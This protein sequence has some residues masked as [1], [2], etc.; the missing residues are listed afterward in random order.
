MNEIITNDYLNDLQ[1]IKEAIRT[2]QNKAMV[3]VNSA[4]IMTYYEIGSRACRTGW[5]GRIRS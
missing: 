5:A 1:K 3:I 4:M 2:N